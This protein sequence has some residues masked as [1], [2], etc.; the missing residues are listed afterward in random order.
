VVK[1]DRIKKPELRRELGLLQATMLGIGGTLSAG[2]FVI[3]GHAAGMAG[4][5]IVVVVIVCGIISLFTMF[6]YCE[7]GTII[8]MAGSEYTFA[9][10]AY[11][12]PVAFIT[13]WFEWISNMFYAALS[14]LGFAYII[15]YLIPVNIPL[16]AALMVLI[17]TAINIRGVK[18]AGTVESLMTISVLVILAF[19]V[20]SGLLQSPSISGFRL[21]APGGLWGALAATAYLFELYLGAEAIAVAQAEVKDPQKTIPRAMMLSSV[22]LIVF[23]TAIVY[24][25][26]MTVPPEILKDQASPIAFAAEQVMGKFGAMLVTVAVAIAGLAAINESIMAQSRTLY[27]LSRDGYFPEALSKIHKR[28]CTPHVAI[29]VSSIFTV[30]LVATGGI[31]FVVYAVNF[32]FIV[33]FCLVNLSLM[34][35]RREKPL[36]GRPFKAP[37]YPFTPIVGIAASLLL[38]FFIEDAA[39]L[40]LGAELTI[41]ALLSYYIRMAGYSRIRSAFGGMSLGIGSLGIL[42]AYLI[43]SDLISLALESKDV[44]IYGLLFISLV[45]IVAGVLNFTTK[46]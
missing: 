25:T 46:S 26:V 20:C 22:G 5:S 10:V 39:V 13:G 35:L 8:P 44:L 19:Y 23:Y 24:A 3:L 41:L 1:R 36:L 27:A 40:I 42:T 34:K 11:G 16:T 31:N 29:L 12:G 38:I 14:S 33:G 6:S 30:T 21:S 37:L 9:K 28:F 43:K 15:S 45:Y 32:G 7:L 18:E 2:N 17:F 4:Y